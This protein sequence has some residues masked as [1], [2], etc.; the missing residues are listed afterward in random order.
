MSPRSKEQYQDIR[1]SRKNQI[2]DA[3]LK[4][5]AK[6][7]LAATKITD[8][9][10]EANLS[11]GLVHHYFKSKEE[12]FIEVTRQTIEKSSTAFTKI[13][14]LE[15]S[16][17]EIIKIITERNILTTDVEENALRWLFM[18]NLTISDVVPQEAKMLSASSYAPLNMITELIRKGQSLGEIVGG[19]PERLTVAYWA[20]IQGLILFRYN[21]ELNL[22]MPEIDTVLRLFKP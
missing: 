1:D 6:R 11:H 4:V 8:I 22:P 18:I 17:L 10:S 16:P 12:I 2:L 7:G 13:A 20:M 9:S 19:E 14:N 15:A 5:F 3:A 21:K